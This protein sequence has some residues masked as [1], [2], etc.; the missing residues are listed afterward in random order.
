MF[1]GADIAT[2]LSFAVLLG[3]FIVPHE[4]NLPEVVL[5][6]VVGVLI[7]GFWI[8]Q[9]FLRIYEKRQTLPEFDGL[10]LKKTEESVEALEAKIANHNSKINAILLRLGLSGA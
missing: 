9:T 10:A 8:A 6:S 5:Y 3:R 7:V 1:K 4:V 2:G